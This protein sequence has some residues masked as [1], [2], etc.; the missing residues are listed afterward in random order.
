ML[1]IIRAG[2]IISIIAGLMVGCEDDDSTPEIEHP[3]SGDYSFTEMTVHVESTTLN[4]SKL[5]FVTQQDGVDS[6]TIDAGSLVLVEMLTYTDVD[7][8]P[9]S[10]TV[11]LR[12]DGSAHLQGTLP[13][14][15]GTGCNPIIAM[16][17]PSSDGTWSADTSTG[18]FSIDLVFDALDIDGTFILEGNQLNILYS[19]FDGH[20]ER[21]ISSVNYMGADVAVEPTCLPVSTVTER[22]LKLTLN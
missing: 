15:V 13:N 12:N 10:G 16:L 3:L 22:V 20:D 18:T 17:E 9:I 4:D 1:K 8:I 6:V 11:N 5:A 19:A 21:T 7:D 2:I 14:N